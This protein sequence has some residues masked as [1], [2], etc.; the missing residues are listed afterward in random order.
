MTLLL[1]IDIGTT[2]TKGI[3][4][5]S[6]IGL[7][8]ESERSCVLH[9]DQ[10]GWAE[11][12]VDQ[13]WSNVASLCHELAEGR[14]IGA[15]GVSGMVPCVILH[16]AQGSPIRRSIQQNDAR[17]GVEIDEL[18][19]RLAGARIL[20]RTGSAITQ[21]SVGPTLMWLKRHEPEAWARTRTIAGSYDTIV[22]MLTGERSVEANWCS[23]HIESLWNRAS[24]WRCSSTSSPASLSR[25]S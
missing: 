19:A 21:Q 24:R 25:V 3:L 1:G 13:W 11:E 2:A 10:P 17:A 7:V 22:R 18:R 12:D 4:L 16:D 20:E 5:D 14:E 23:C 6:S 8:A 9:S 15:I